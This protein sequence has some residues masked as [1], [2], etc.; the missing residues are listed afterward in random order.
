M[1]EIMCVIWLK[2]MIIFRSLHQLVSLDLWC[3]SPVRPLSSPFHL[4]GWWSDLTCSETC[5]ACFATKIEPATFWN[6]IIWVKDFFKR[7]AMHQQ[8]P[9]CFGRPWA[10]VIANHQT[11]LMLICCWVG[12]TGAYNYGD[13]LYGTVKIEK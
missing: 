3:S 11:T 9:R 6:N 2:W 7:Q 1:N 13:F 10:A 12:I 5:P 4:F 8:L